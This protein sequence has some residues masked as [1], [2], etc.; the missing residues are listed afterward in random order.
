MTTNKTDRVNLAKLFNEKT[1][2]EFANEMYFYEK[3]SG[4]KCNRNKLLIRLAKVP[5][6]TAGSHKKIFLKQNMVII[7]SW[8]NFW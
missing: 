5:A 1:L 8:W 2:F 4:K 3:A 7:E 6:I